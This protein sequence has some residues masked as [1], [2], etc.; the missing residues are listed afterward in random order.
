MFTE[1]SLRR[2]IMQYV[3]PT[4][5]IALSFLLVILF[6]SILLCLPIANRLEPLSYL[7]NLFISTSA[8]CVTGLVPV[9][10][11]EQYNYF[12]YVVLLGLIQ[13]GGL[14]IMS[15]IAFVLT[16][17]KSRLFHTEKRMIQDALNKES[18]QDIP[19]FLKSIV[20]Y[21][22]FFEL[23]GAGL[24]AIVFIPDFGLLKG[25]FNSVFLSVSAF[26]NAG[27]DNFSYYS[28]AEYA[29]NPI[30]NITVGALIVI[31]GLGFAVWFDLRNRLFRRDKKRRFNFKIA[32][33]SLTVQTKIVIITTVGLILSGAVLFLISE[34]LSKTTFDG[35]NPIEVIQTS[36]FQSITLRTAGFST[37]DFSLLQDSSLFFMLGYMLI[38]GSPGG[39]AGGV[40]TTALVM[41]ILMV[42]SQLENQETIV[43]FKRTIVKAAFHRALMVIVCYVMVLFVAVFILSITESIAF[44]PLLFEAVSAIATVGLS[45][46]VTPL[47]SEI[48]KIVIIILMF[49]GRVGP[50]TIA[51]SL[52]KRKGTIKPHE[53]IYPNGEVLIG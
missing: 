3:G 36:I 22:L 34:I 17:L 28:L 46:G 42:K 30:I 11:M 31:G 40:K 38:G 20:K 4:R 39:T 1:K 5:M 37:V 15:L 32:V 26:C 6:G 14:G 51:L 53:V 43:L 12:G 33:Q 13:V 48:G 21:T 2:K 49:I 44:L 52:I 9:N 41:M 16:L 25:I 19:K 10:I 29:T 8:T 35:M 24:I 18:L 7:D 45:A 23:V 47:L 50:I 27:I